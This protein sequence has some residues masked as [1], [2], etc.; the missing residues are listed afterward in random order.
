[1]LRFGLVSF[2]VH[3]YSTAAPEGAR[4]AF[5]QLHRDCHSRIRYVKQCPIHGPVTKD[6]IV[7]GYEF[8]KGQYVEIEPA[9]L[10]ELRTERERALT[11]D[12]FIDREELDFVYLDGRSYYLTPAGT[13]AGEPYSVFLQALARKKRYGIG[14]FVMSGREQVVLVRPYESVL[15]MEM[16]RYASE[17]RDPS[18]LV[19]AIPAIRLLDKKLRL[20]EQVIEQWA[21]DKFDYRD[22][23]DHYQNKVR[24]LI[25][26]KVEGKEL[27]TPEAEDEPEVVNLMDALRRS[28]H[29]GGTSRS[30]S[31]RVA[32][33]KRA[34]AAR[35]RVKGRK[36]S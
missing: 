12:N 7:S 35:H 6:D 23:V 17:V 5:H 4:V 21:D 16:L 27:V 26:A 22:Y 31:R 1:M 2:P 19:G 28:V 15:T 13:D 20:A 30:T 33:P 24:E 10:D 3:A 18:N 9:D 34:T 14:Q 29:R 25:E 36:A 32:K 8:S 11:I